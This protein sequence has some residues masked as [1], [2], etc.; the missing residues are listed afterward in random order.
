MYH[1][2]EYL[3]QGGFPEIIK[4]MIVKEKIMNEYFELVVYKDIIDRYKIKNTKLITWLI[5]SCIASAAAELSIH[6]TF[7]DLKSQSVKASKNTLYNYLSLLEDSLFL[8]IVSK[9]AHSIKKRNPLI[10]KTYINDACFFKRIDASKNTGKK[11]EN[12]TYLEL[13]R[14]K[15]PLENIHYYKNVQGEEVDFVITEGNRVT[16]LIQ[17]CQEMDAMKT[18]QREVRA[19]CKAGAELGC[20]NLIIITE[21][22]ERTE[23]FV[24]FGKKA[25][26]TSN[27]LWKWLLREES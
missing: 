1:L 27:P 11:M 8:F 5:H 16:Q 24:W 2:D 17:V 25:R 9:Y 18:R 26:I 21:D 13:L 22:K 14:R 20:K 3:Q 19:L 12:A 4:D 23:D 10:N 15:K 7:L 6:K